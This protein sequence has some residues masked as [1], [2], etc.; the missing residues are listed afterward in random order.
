MPGSNSRPNVSEG[1]KVTSELPGRPAALGTI[2]VVSLLYGEFSF[3]MVFL[4]KN[5]NAPKPYI[6]INI[7]YNIA[8]TQS[9]AGDL[10]CDHGF[11][12][13]ISFY[14]D[15]VYKTKTKKL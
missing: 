10:P 2:I 7:T 9:G 1:C 8:S 5:L 6:I 3:R 13:G 14:E 12:F 15:S 11:G 4:R